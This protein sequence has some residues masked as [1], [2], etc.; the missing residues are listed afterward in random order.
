[1]VTPEQLQGLRSEESPFQELQLTG[2]LPH[3]K[4]L[5][6]VTPG[7]LQGVWEMLGLKPGEESQFYEVRAVE[8]F[9]TPTLA[10]QKA[11]PW[12]QKFNKGRYGR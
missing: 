4:M 3:G 7:Q 1:M 10:P 2:A 11:A 5:I 12:Y 9:R 8:A 6:L